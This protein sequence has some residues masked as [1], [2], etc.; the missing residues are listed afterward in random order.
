MYTVE[1]P[2][3]DTP[4]SGHPPNN[5]RQLMYQLLFPLLPNSGQP[6]NSGQRT[7][8]THRTTLSYRSAPPITDK[9]WGFVGGVGKF[10]ASVV[11]RLTPAYR[12]SLTC[13]CCILANRHVGLHLRLYSR[14]LELLR[15]YP[16]HIYTR[17]YAL[18]KASS[19]TMTVY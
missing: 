17:P 18:P 14:I 5:G 6:P 8:L 15:R 2:I 9:G 19:K 4:N 1:P 12:K 7:S 3:T 13:A 10:C 11:T 16:E